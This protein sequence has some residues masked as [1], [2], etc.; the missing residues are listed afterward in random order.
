MTDDEILADMK[1]ILESEKVSGEFPG[2][3]EREDRDSLC[4]NVALDILS[5]S[6]GT[7]RL[8][9]RAVKGCL[10]RDCSATL[11]TTIQGRDLRAWRMDWRP[12][13][14]HTNRCGP[15]EYKGLVS[16]TGIHQFACNAKLG[17]ERMQAEDLPICIPVDDEPHD[18]DAFIRYACAALKIAVTDP[19][20][21]PP[22]SAT[23]F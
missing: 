22:W 14:S 15:R 1:Q 20:L 19:I 10:D 2:W 16:W 11:I 7:A 6:I 8:A 3:R 9:L 23:L 17:L 13:H 12:I 21:G 18:F 5:Q 4:L